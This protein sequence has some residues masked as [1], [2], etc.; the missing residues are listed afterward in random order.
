MICRNRQ[1]LP[2]SLLIE[3]AS[4]RRRDSWKISYPRHFRSSLA[5]ICAVTSSFLLVEPLAGTLVGRAL[6]TDLPSLRPCRLR[7]H[8][9]LLIRR[10]VRAQVFD[11]G[12]SI[13]RIDHRAPLNHLIYFFRPRGFLQPLLHYDARVMAFQ[14]C[15]PHLGLQRSGRQIGRLWAQHSDARERQE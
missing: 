9:R 3:N 15:C 13:R 10:E 4:D 1:R 12:I 14:A 11:E 7:R 2:S 6:T 5:T 8:I